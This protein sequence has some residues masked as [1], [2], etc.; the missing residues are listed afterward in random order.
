MAGPARRPLSSTLRKP[1]HA[2][3]G[4]RPDGGTRRRRS[5]GHSAPRLREIGAWPSVSEIARAAGPSATSPAD[6]PASRLMRSRMRPASVG[7]LADEADVVAERPH[8]AV[9]VL[10]GGRCRARVPGRRSTTVPRGVASSWAAPAASPASATSRSERAAR[11]RAC[12]EFAASRAKR[13]RGAPRSESRRSSTAAT[14]KATHMP[15][16][17]NTMSSRMREAGRGLGERREEERPETGDRQRHEHPGAAHGLRM[18]AASV[19]STR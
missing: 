7:L 5:P 13:A 15:R 10:E 4:E 19:R 2:G 11:S 17:C 3:P 12:G 8:P 14:A 6:A 1:L 18:S 16:R 9:V